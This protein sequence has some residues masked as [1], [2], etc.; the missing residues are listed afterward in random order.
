MDMSV[1]YWLTGD[2]GTLLFI[3]N[4]YCELFSGVNVL[5]HEADYSV[6]LM[7]CVKS[8]FFFN[9]NSGWWIPAGVTRH[10]GHELAFCTYPG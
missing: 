7:R 5:E 8:N 10:V 4:D 3:W 6:H 9:S 2:H 1:K